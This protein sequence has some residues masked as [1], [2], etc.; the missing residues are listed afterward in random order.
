VCPFLITLPAPSL[1][2][3]AK[4]RFGAGPEF[5]VTPP[6]KQKALAAARLLLRQYG[7]SHV[8]HLAVESNIAVGR[9]C[10]SSTSDCVAAVRAAAKLV[11]VSPSR[12]EI[13]RIVNEA[14][15]ATDPTMYD[16]VVAF[17]H[18]HGS[19]L[20]AFTE[21]LPPMRVL[22][23]DT[24]PDA[25]GV[26]TLCLPERRYS[27]G[28][29]REYALLLALFERAIAARSLRCLAAIAQTSAEFNQVVLP[30]RNYRAYCRLAQDAGAQGVAI[31]HSGTV[32]SLLSS[33]GT[34]LVPWL[35]SEI[36]RLGGSV[37]TAYAIACGPHEATP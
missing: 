2:S 33:P 20:R 36:E 18:R 6:E 13:A 27:A 19:P 23:V 30:T 11:C 8:I 35:G 1:I 21:T 25:P 26:D 37:V 28:E 34:A 12:D 16:A 15:R 22:V 24:Q 29:L 3:I 4:A 32:I 14:E 7:I 10:G 5:S 9:G 31:A 17:R